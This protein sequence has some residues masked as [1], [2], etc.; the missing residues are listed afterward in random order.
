MKLSLTEWIVLGI[1]S[2]GSTHGFSVAKLLA[3]EGAAG[4]IWTVPRPLVYRAIDVLVASGYVEFL[5]FTAGS[6]PPRRPVVATSAGKLAHRKWLEE[7]V[8]HVRDARSHLLMKLF[9]HSRRNSSPRKLIDHQLELLTPMI[10][11]LRAQL[12]QAEGFDVVLVRWRISSVE[13]LER[14]LLEIR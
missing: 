10:V 3:P 14:F 4:E 6:G 2:E 12:S 11:G 13:A 5:G 7:P 8:S 1:I 9:F